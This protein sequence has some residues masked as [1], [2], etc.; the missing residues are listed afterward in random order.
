M[1]NATSW[2]SWSLMLTCIVLGSACSSKQGGNTSGGS[3]GF[4]ETCNPQG[5]STGGLTGGGLSGGTTG[6]GSLNDPN[7]CTVDPSLVETRCATASGN[8]NGVYNCI[9]GQLKCLACLY[10]GLPGTPRQIELVPCGCGDL[11]QQNTCDANGTWLPGACQPQQC[12]NKTSKCLQNDGCAPGDSEVRPC[13]GPPDPTANSNH[14]CQGQTF[15]CDDTCTWQAQSP[16]CVAMAPQCFNFGSGGETS[17]IQSCGFCGTRTVSCDGCFYAALSTCGDEQGVCEPGEAITS[18]CAA[19]N[20]P[21]GGVTRQTCN[22]QCQWNPPSSCDIECL[23]NQTRETAQP[24]SSDPNVGTD[25]CGNENILQV[26]GQTS[27]QACGASGP[28]LPKYQW[29]YEGQVLDT[30][31]CSPPP[32]TPIPPP[33]PPPA[34]CQLTPCV[35]G[36]ATNISCN[37]PC[38]EPGTQVQTCNSD[39]CGYTLGP[40]IADQNNACDPSKGTSV[41]DIGPC[42]Q[43]ASQDQYKQCSASTCRY[44]FTTC[45]VCQ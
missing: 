41:I 25:V 40:C 31:G 35:A 37:N 36:T 16:N 11:Q 42:P 2:L 22:A 1:K 15:I 23:P 43:C 3:T 33:P 18:P 26:C 4:C 28:S 6:S 29:Q 45:T 39:N 12:P 24:C 30:N 9:N 27:V 34:G 21:T 38:G 17:I 7:N 20:C 8:P 19:D 13:D 44:Q 10:E 32:C 14:N 5:G